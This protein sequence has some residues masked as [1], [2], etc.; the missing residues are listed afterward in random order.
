[1]DNL[2][3]TISDVKEKI[4]ILN[5]LITKFESKIKRLQNSKIQELCENFKYNY[6][7]LTGIKRFCIP[8]FGKIS[9]GK[10]TLLNYILHFHGD[11]ETDYNISTKFVCIVRHNPNL[12]NTSK[13]YNVS[14]NKRDEYKKDDKTYKLWNFEKGEEIVGD[15]KEIIEK[16]NH[17]L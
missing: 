14:V 1:M 9:S 4:D 3:K 5:Y 7:T 11:F 2:K 16:R 17:D 8:V 6:N 10:S 15:V 12:I 13:I